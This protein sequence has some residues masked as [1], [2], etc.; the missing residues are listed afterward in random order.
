MYRRYSVYCCLAMSFFMAKYSS[1]S[2]LAPSS[3]S[4]SFS[5]TLTRFTWQTN[6]QQSTA[7]LSTGEIKSVASSWWIWTVYGYMYMYTCTEMQVL[8][9][10]SQPCPQA[11]YRMHAHSRNEA[12][13]VC[14][15][16]YKKGSITHKQC[17][18][19]HFRGG[20]VK[21]A[22]VRFIYRTSTG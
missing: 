16:I 18:K 3:S 4:F 9:I 6:R 1:A 13:Q 12:L 7:F 5:T 22:V 11:E 17:N 15:A 19:K 14:R 20:S 10:T 8:S 2:F 21:P